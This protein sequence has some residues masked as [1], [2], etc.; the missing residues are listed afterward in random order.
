MYTAP[1][2]FKQKMEMYEAINFRV[3]ITIYDSKYLCI[4]H[5]VNYDKCLKN[6]IKMTF[7]FWK[8]FWKIFIPPRL[9]ETCLLVWAPCVLALRAAWKR[10]YV[11]DGGLLCTK[12]S[13]CFE[14]TTS[15]SVKQ[16]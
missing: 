6:K 15:S 2:V 13:R 8:L 12:K 5:D 3:V 4:K 11:Q 7:L 10:Y 14:E 16:Y 1:F 9:C